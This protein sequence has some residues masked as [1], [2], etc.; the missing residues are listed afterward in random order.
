[1]V[2]T[3]SEVVKSVAQKLPDIESNSF[4]AYFDS[5]GQSRV[6]LIGD[7][8]HGTSEFYRARAAIT[9]RLIQE[10]GFSIVAIEGDWP[11]CRVID[12]YVRQHPSAKTT[13]I[14]VFKHFPE[15]MWRD[16]EV[17]SF[18]DWLQ[19]H[20]AQ[21]P[22]E[23][24]AGFFG[25]DLYSMASSIRAVIDYL[26]RVDPETAK[27]A[28]KRYG[29]LEP[30]LEDPASYG[31]AAFSKGYAPCESGV[32]K[33]LKELLTK[34]LALMSAENADTYLDAEMN[35][36]LVRDSEQYYHAMYYDDSVS[37]NLR[38][39]HMFATLTRLLKMQPG[40]KAVVWAHNSHL[41]DAG[42][43]AMAPSRDELSLGQLCRQKFFD[44]GEVSII[45]CGT[46]DGE[47][48]AADEWDEPMQIM[49]VNPSREDSYE[50]IMHDTGIPS[51]LL[52]LRG[53][54]QKKEVIEA[55]M[56]PR[57]E[58]FIGVIYC[59][60]TERYSHY[61]EAVL[62]QQFDALLWFDRTTAVKAF[63]VAQPKEALARGETYPFGL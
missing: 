46:H 19:V 31:Q 60:A 45:G 33:I 58:R 20:N 14:S 62:P 27:V 41:G 21:L 10:N 17:Q 22:Q 40:A 30:W 12:S 6:V 15:W 2:Q 29:C 63:E 35:A 28:R 11:D 16:E 26:D 36:R 42:A 53:E 55:L 56:K 9:K 32:I 4:S 47:V 5:F 8:S 25:L 1:M 13:P 51:F 57:L 3:L 38:D 34:R 43:T 24:R 7:A 59:P 18:V 52:D 44:L 50:R 61:M 54:R 39:T 23:K 48:A 37:W 49:C